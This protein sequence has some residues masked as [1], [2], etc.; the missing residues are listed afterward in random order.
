M[1]R[2]PHCMALQEHARA[3]HT[4]WVSQSVSMREPSCPV[5]LHACSKTC[6]LC[7]LWHCHKPQSKIHL[8]LG[9]LHGMQTQLACLKPA[10]AKAVW[11]TWGLAPTAWGDEPG[12]VNA[13]AILHSKSAEPSMAVRG[14][15]FTGHSMSL[16]Q[17]CK[18]K[19]HCAVAAAS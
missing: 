10:A 19:L 1:R 9:V 15:H 2:Q 12:S 7:R 5:M 16:E 14:E 4:S 13:V 18:V 17:Q 11:T 3:E 8:V 6:I